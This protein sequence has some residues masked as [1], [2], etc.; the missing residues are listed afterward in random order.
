MGEQ[1][2]VVPVHRPDL[3]PAEAA[4]AAACLARGELSGNGSEVAAFERE[5]AAYVGRSFAIATSSGTT[6]LELTWLALGLGP[7]D[8]VIVPSFSFAPCADAVHRVGAHAVYADCDPRSYGLTPEHAE[9]VLTPATRA[10]L[11][12]SMYGQPCDLSGLEAWCRDRGLLLIEDGA[13][14]LGATHRGRPVGSFGVAGCFSFY[15]NKLVACGEG[16]AVVTDD[17][18]FADR[19]RLLRSNGVRDNAERPYERI[20]RGTGVR[21]GALAAAVGRVQL[22]RVEE[23]LLRRQQH[24][25]RYAEELAGHVSFPALHP[26]T[27]RHARWANLV[28]VDDHAGFVERLAAQGVQ[29]RGA[30]TPLHCMDAGDAVMPGSRDVAAR[31]V[32]L[33]SGNGLTAAD[34]DRVVTAVRRAIS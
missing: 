23:F 10:V 21:M 11:A 32:V 30:Y 6:A 8:E 16:G 24:A 34:V 28:L 14:S 12:V 29:T 13:Q 31:G 19:L 1:A 17:A 25:H 18:A 15:A 3:G 4:A 2:A 5:L 9:A 20:A 27:T 7:G 33:P 26:D 22:G